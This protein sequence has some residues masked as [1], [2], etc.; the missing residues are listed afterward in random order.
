MLNSC[1][2]YK[3]HGLTV[4]DVENGEAEKDD[5]NS[6]SETKMVRFTSGRE[7]MMVI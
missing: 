2:E 7:V 1:D 5:Y 4:D 3:Y 6:Y